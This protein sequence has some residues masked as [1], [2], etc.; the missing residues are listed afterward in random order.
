ML[1]KAVGVAGCGGGDQWIAVVVA[2]VAAVV[3]DV[4]ADAYVLTAAQLVVVV[5]VV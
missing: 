1:M 5:A 3:S 2:A 4:A